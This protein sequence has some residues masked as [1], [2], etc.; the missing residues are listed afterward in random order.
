MQPNSLIDSAKGWHNL[1]LAVM[2]FIGF[3]GVQQMGEPWTAPAWLNVWWLGMSAL[4]FISSLIS[5]WLV[6]GVA[7]PLYGGGDPMNMP[8]NAVGR[9][10][11][12]I[13][14]TFTAVI[15]MV[16]AALPGWWPDGGGDSASQVE[17]TD[18]AG[19]SACGT[20]VEGAPAGSMWLRTAEGLITV[21]LRQMSD[22]RPVSSC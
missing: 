17:V 6:G 19:A 2:G 1:Q 21:S 7:F 14:M 3:C 18:T 9:L 13:R 12:G 8:A 16:L 22:V 4:A 5:M 11:A 15:M 10:R 20:W